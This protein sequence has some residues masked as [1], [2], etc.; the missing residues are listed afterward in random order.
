MASG[1]AMVK[2]AVW[3]SGPGSTGSKHRATCFNPPLL[4]LSLDWRDVRGRWEKVRA[5]GSQL[6]EKRAEHSSIFQGE[7]RHISRSGVDLLDPYLSCQTRLGIGVIAGQ[8]VTRHAKI[9]NLLRFHPPIP[10]EGHARPVPI[11]SLHLKGAG[12]S[13]LILFFVSS[14]L[15]LH[16]Q[17][18]TETKPWANVRSTPLSRKPTLAAAAPGTATGGPTG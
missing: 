8:T 17:T 14:P 10:D 1:T 13:C 2:A 9:K 6:N 11:L 7:A 5:L 16:S 12:L 18:Q 3:E 4:G 15:Q